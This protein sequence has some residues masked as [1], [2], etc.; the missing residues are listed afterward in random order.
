MTGQGAPL[1]LMGWSTFDTKNKLASHPSNIRSCSISR[2]SD[3]YIII[4][5]VPIFRQGPNLY[6]GI[7]WTKNLDSNFR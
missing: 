7:R 5:D 3:R 2:R 1:E 4:S 6:A